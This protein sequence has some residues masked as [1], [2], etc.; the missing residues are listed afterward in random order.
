MKLIAL[1]AVFAFTCFLVTPS[2]QG[3][4]LQVNPRHPAAGQSFTIDF[5]YV[6]TC[7]GPIDDR[8]GVFADLWPADPSMNFVRV[9]VDA[10]IECFDS[11]PSHAV[12]VSAPITGLASGT[13]PIYS[14]IAILNGIGLPLQDVVLQGSVTVGPAAAAS[15]VPAVSTWSLVLLMI[16]VAATCLIARR[17]GNRTPPQNV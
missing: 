17:G 11:A 12:H 8:F 6:T 7:I 4:A 9:L 14:R 13:Y 10:S 15:P 5:D 16:G 2:A 3:S 1:C